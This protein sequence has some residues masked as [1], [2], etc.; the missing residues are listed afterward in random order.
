[1]RFAGARVL[2]TGGT[3]F[4]GGVVARRLVEEG[5]LV[6]ALARPKADTRHL[7]NL[8]V[9][10]REGNVAVASSLD[11]SD[12][13]VVVH[14]AAWVGLGVPR[15]KRDLFWL[16]NVGGTANVVEAA[17]RA[18]V[19][20]LVHVSTIAALPRGSARPGRAA[21]EAD[22]D[23]SAIEHAPSFYSKSKMEAHRIVLESGLHVALPMPAVVLGPGGPFEPVLRRLANGRLRALPSGDGVKAWAHVEDVAEGVLLA[24]LRGSGPYLLVDDCVTTSELLARLAHVVD[25]PVPRRRVPVSALA[26]AAAVVEAA[27]HAVG[28]TPPVSRELIEGLREPMTYDSA[29]AREDLGWRPDLWRRVADDVRALRAPTKAELKQREASEKREARAAKARAK[30]ARRNARAR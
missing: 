20:K 4:I 19:P 12:Q 30:A 15:K 11:F 21:V 22:F 9:T 7:R 1:M 25:V 5:A 14:A 26:A 2:L 24:A 8:G 17:R 27:Y 13:D 28:K 10:V 29:R 23:A 18:D 6:T 3:G 16:T